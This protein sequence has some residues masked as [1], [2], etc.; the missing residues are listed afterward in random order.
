M[1]KVKT[2]SNSQSVKR[3]HGSR[4]PSRSIPVPKKANF[5]PQEPQEQE[6]RQPTNRARKSL[7]ELN[8]TWAE[9]ESLE[10]A[11]ASLMYLPVMLKSRSVSAIL[12]SSSQAH[13]LTGSEVE[14]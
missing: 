1:L 7:F 12:F 14:I 13:F 9:R 8:A 3:L 5:I 4:S 6:R 11:V 10:D 2:A